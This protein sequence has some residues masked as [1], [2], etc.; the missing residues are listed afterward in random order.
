MNW[1]LKTII[2]LILHLLYLEILNILLMHDIHIHLHLVTPKSLSCGQDTSTCTAFEDPTIY[3]GSVA[4]NRMSK[5][6][7]SI[8]F[9]QTLCAYSLTGISQEMGPYPK[10]I[11]PSFRESSNNSIFSF[12]S[13]I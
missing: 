13:Y 6:C 11:Q 3:I 8:C 2:I 5:R 9:W 10:L 12:L 4:H 7:Y 1:P